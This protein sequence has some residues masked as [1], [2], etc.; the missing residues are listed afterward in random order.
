[1]MARCTKSPYTH[2]SELTAL[3]RLIL[4][5]PYLTYPQAFFLNFTKV[6]G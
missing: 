4:M 5:A 2:L 6:D 1:M 3:S